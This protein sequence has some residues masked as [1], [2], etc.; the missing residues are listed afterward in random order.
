[1]ARH[2][3]GPFYRTS[4]NTWYVTHQGRKVSLRVSGRRNKKEAVEA[5]HRLLRGE[6]TVPEGPPPAALTVRQ[7]VK[8]FLSAAAVKPSTHELYTRHLDRFAADL[9]GLGVAELTPHHLT[10]WLQGLEVGSTTQK[11]MLSSVGSF[12][13]WCVRQEI[14]DRNPASAV[15]KPKGR[16]RGREAVVS[17][18]DHAKLLRAARPELRTVLT[19]LH[20]TGARPAEVCSITAENFDPEA[21]V[22]R[23][24]DHKTDRTGRDRIIHL[25]PPAVKLLKGLVRKYRTGPLLRHSRGGPWTRPAVG[26]QVRMI[27]NRIGIKVIPYGYRHTLA[28]DALAEGVPDALVAE[29]LGHSGTAMIHKHYGH[30]GERR[31]VLAEAL[32]RVR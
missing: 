21:A 6:R 12:M 19:L 28:T 30:L 22:I 27:C 25:P 29:L 7:T 23:L 5:W 2:V 24:T 10:K 26:Y 11:I 32:R 20:L 16:S 15:A 31:R 17:S 8:V 9:G 14:I 13:G 18:Q 3:E 4:K 1:M